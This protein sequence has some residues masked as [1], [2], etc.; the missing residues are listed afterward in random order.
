MRQHLILWSAWLVLLLYAS[1]A[2]A[3]T[4]LTVKLI[5]DAPSHCTAAPQI[6]FP[7]GTSQWHRVDKPYFSGENDRE[8]YFD[9]E[10][11]Q[12][13]PELSRVTITAPGVKIIRAIVGRTDVPFQRVD[14]RITLQLVD[15]QA[16]GQ[17]MQTDYQSPR[18][19]LPISF[20]HEW[21][22]RRNGD[23][24]KDP[25]PETQIE[26]VPNYLVAAQEA[27]RLLGYGVAGTPVPYLG[28]VVLMGSE[29]ATTRGHTDYPPHFHIMHYEFDI[30]GSNAKEALMDDTPTV[31]KWRSRLAPHFYM[32]DQGQVISNHFAVLVGAGKSATLDIGQTCTL[33]DSQGHFVLDM[34]VVKDGLMLGNGNDSYTL[35]P[36]P[37]GGAVKAVDGYHG[38]ELAF[39][40]EVHDDAAQGHLRYRIETFKGGKTVETFN[41]GYDYD[42]FTAKLT[43]RNNDRF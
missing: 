14:D 9:I 38:D 2:F 8:I 18:G 12:T 31:K 35:R 43:K 6:E 36:D 21:K 3:G 15:D 17:M 34:T 23:Y 11:F 1:S 42:P 37:V 5:K 39:R 22:M 4:T 32:D 20:R 41:D 30:V 33:K 7:D 19:G 40:V 13:R 16:Q 29:N 26:A 27:L 24:L 28:E 25:Y 10:S